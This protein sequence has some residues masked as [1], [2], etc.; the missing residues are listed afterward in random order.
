MCSLDCQLLLAMGLRQFLSLI[1]VAQVKM[2]KI[3]FVSQKDSLRSWET[4]QFTQNV[5]T[6]SGAQFGGFF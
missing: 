2:S 1:I 6:F 5:V 4:A 3:A